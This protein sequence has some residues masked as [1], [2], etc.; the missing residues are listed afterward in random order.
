MDR[1]RARLKRVRAFVWALAAICFLSAVDLSA[2]WIVATIVM[3][4]PRRIPVLPFF[5]LVLVFNRGIGFGLLSDL[6]GWGPR[7]LSGV[8]VGIVGMLF[9]WL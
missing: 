7:I 6:G 9:V 4:P 1:G 2:K 5:D 8:A 3:D